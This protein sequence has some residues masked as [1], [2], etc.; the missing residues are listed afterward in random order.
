MRQCQPKTVNFQFVRPQKEKW[1]KSSKSLKRLK[2]LPASGKRGLENAANILEFVPRFFSNEKNQLQ[3]L[4]AKR[5][6]VISHPL[7]PA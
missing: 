1:M 2:N 5:L 7:S 4:I 6:A 3:F